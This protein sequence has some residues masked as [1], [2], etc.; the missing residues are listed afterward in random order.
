LNPLNQVKVWYRD[1]SVTHTR[2]AHFYLRLLGLVYVAAFLSFGWQLPGLVGPQ[3]ILPFAHTLDRVRESWGL[4]AFLWFP[5]FFWLGSSGAWLS[6]VCYVGAGLGAA[7]MAGFRSRWLLF[8]IWYLFYSVATSADVFGGYQWE[9][10]LLEA[11]FLAI[12]SSSGSKLGVLLQRWLLFRLVFASGVVKLL[13]Q[14]P[15]WWNLSAVEYH[16]FTQP[17]PTPIAWLV[18]QLDSRVLKGFTFLTLV[19]EILLPLFFFFPKPVRKWAAFAQ[20]GLQFT[21]LLT[22]N[23]AYFNWLSLA[24]CV[25][26]FDDQDFPARFPR[27]SPGRAKGWEWAV[28]IVIL[29]F[30]FFPDYRFP[31]SGRYGLFAR[32]TTTHTMLEIQGSADGKEWRTYHYRND[33][34]SFIAPHQPRLQWQAWFAGLT[35][36]DQEP[37]LQRLCMKLFKG[38]PAVTALFANNPF[39]TTPPNLIRIMKF[40]VE[41]TDWDERKRGYWRKGKR[42]EYSPVL[43]AQLFESLG[44]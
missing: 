44:L 17:L 43:T 39:P 12:L 6:G 2:V 26:L 19:G 3:G 28:A 29:W 7:L 15:T 30:S 37:W 33:P 34:P 11:G 14:D 16:L 25:W 1:A 31:I 8:I 20:I 35:S 22:G 9:F 38:E 42:T 21:F 13:S 24:L 18:H 40:D 36:F 27:P 10:L 23:F 4:S 32:M 5:N 41:F